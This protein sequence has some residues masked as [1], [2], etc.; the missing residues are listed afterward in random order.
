MLPAS[1]TW[2]TVVDKDGS[3]E[4]ITIVVFDT[5]LHLLVYEILQG[6]ATRYKTLVDK[7]VSENLDAIKSKE[8]LQGCKEWNRNFK[9]INWI[10]RQVLTNMINIC[11]CYQ[12]DDVVHTILKALERFLMQLCFTIN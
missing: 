1:C 6:L 7:T 10:C 11:A 4:P 12:M 8:D 2:S 3:G 9:D 5:N